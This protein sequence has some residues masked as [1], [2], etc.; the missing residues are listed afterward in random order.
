LQ[1]PTAD[2]RPRDGAWVFGGGSM[3]AEV[4]RRA[5]EKERRQA[6]GRAA[7]ACMRRSRDAAAGK[8][9]TEKDP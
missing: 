9:E 5:C 8:R 7:A 1:R 2:P 3:A 6:P 4:Q